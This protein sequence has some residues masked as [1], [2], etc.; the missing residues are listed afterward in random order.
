MAYSNGGIL[1]CQVDSLVK[2]LTFLA[3]VALGLAS[4]GCKPERP[5]GVSVAPVETKREDPAA[6]VVVA[7]INDRLIKFG[8]IEERL[9][10][11]PV[12]VRVRHQTAERKLEFV[13][14]YLEYTV[15]ALDAQERGYAKDGRVIQALKDDIAERWLRRTV[16]LSVKTSDIPEDAITKAYE[17]RYL[18]FNRPERHVVRQILFSDYETAYKLAYRIRKT[19]ETTD[20]SHVDVFKEFVDEWSV[21]P[22][23]K[24]QGGLIGGFPRMAGEGPEMP[25]EVSQVVQTLSMYA[26]VSG[27]VADAGG[28]R[29]LFLDSIEPAVSK[30]LDQAKGEIVSGL[31]KIETAKLR[32]QYLDQL[33]KDFGVEVDEDAVRRAIEAPKSEVDN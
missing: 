20:R 27:V 12:F 29:V 10:S 9:E 25:P 22:D 5:T 3:I 2:N 15:L 7:R 17:E 6:E 11:L 23:S 31:M 14:S 8:E 30:N 26:R 33:R 21:D 16:D 13:E 1:A 24:A 19:I 32:R 18:E 28:Y 4:W